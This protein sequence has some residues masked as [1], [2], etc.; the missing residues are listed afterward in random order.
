MQR[1]KHCQE[2]YPEW[3]ETPTP[4]MM[5]T[6]DINQPDLHL[7]PSPCR[8]KR[9]LLRYYGTSY[10]TTLPITLR[11]YLLLYYAT[12]Y[13]TTLPTTLLRYLL[14][15]YTTCYVTTLPANLLRYLLHY[16]A[17]YCITTLFLRYLLRS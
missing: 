1:G 13:I 8:H 4:S 12:Y 9:Y 14:R 7:P 2:R 5:T 10:V 11:R 16:Y 6:S 15:Y 17:T 3:K